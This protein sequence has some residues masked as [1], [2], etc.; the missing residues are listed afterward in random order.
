MARSQRSPVPVL[1]LAGLLLGGGYNYHRNFETETAVPR[2]YKGY[3]ESDLK[4]LLGAYQSENAALESRYSS[5]RSAARRSPSGRLLDEN[6]RAFELAQRQ[7]S[8]SRN[9]EGPPPAAPDD[10]T[11]LVT[12]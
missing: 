10:L 5:S 4:T 12:A 3:S 9:D 6:I 1:L 8:R 7:A 2:P 11:E